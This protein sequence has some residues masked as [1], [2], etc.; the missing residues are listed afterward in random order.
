MQGLCSH[1]LLMG[2]TSRISKS[3]TQP[4]LQPWRN[5]AETSLA[6]LT[7][8]PIPESKEDQGGINWT[9]QQDTF[10]CYAEEA[11]TIWGLEALRVH[12]TPSAMGAAGACPDPSFSRGCPP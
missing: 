11:I 1:H 12:G 10:G 7:I 6:L 4:S 9:G 3:H 5:P 2:T 8:P